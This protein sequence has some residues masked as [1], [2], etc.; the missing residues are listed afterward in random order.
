MP[1]STNWHWL[2]NLFDTNLLL[3]S[4]L[5]LFTGN[6]FIAS[7]F[8]PLHDF[9]DE[10]SLDSVGLNHNKWTFVVGSHLWWKGREDSK[11][12]RDH[13]VHYVKG[14][15]ETPVY[16]VADCQCG[17]NSSYLNIFV[18]F[19]FQQL[20]LVHWLTTIDWYGIPKDNV[21]R[22]GKSSFIKIT[23]SFLI[24]TIIFTLSHHKCLSHE[25]W[26]QCIIH[27]SCLITYTL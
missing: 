15:W 8:K 18:H 26:I 5:H 11:Q 19:Y 14:S 4:Y 23:L 12:G 22:Y 25:I 10:S 24:C 16:H 17:K 7:L 2:N 27:I 13:V 3:V 20:V 21:V 6:E 9:T 1:S